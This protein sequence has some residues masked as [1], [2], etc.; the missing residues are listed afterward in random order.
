MWNHR[1]NN[2]ATSFHVDQLDKGDLQDVFIR[3]WTKN[4]YNVKALCIGLF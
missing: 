3:E 2:T 1:G 4:T